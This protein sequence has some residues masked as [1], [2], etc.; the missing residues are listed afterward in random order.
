MTITELFELQLRQ[1]DRLINETKVCKE[2]AFYCIF[3]DM[4]SAS[5]A[6]TLL[7][8]TK[9]LSSDRYSKK[10]KDYIVSIAS[11]VA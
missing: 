5:F 3:S 2:T 1:L 7:S 8:K 9:M 6:N 10:C 4:P 11:E